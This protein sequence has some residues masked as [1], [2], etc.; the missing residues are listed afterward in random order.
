MKV[1]DLISIMPDTYC[2]IAINEYDGVKHTGRRYVIP[3]H[4]T[5]FTH[6]PADIWNHEVSAM[7]PYF[8]RIS[9]EINIDPQ[10]EM[11]YTHA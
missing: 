8:G 6:I 4:S 3:E 10:F 2:E 11:R 5:D 1:C 7:M 9:I